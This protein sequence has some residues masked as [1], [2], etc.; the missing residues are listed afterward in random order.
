MFLLG[1]MLS[2]CLGAKLLLTTRFLAGPKL[3]EAN[4]LDLTRG[5]HIANVQCAEVGGWVGA[6]ASGWI[7]GWREL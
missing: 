5:G 4:W 6:A 1:W 3:Y 7:R 2:N